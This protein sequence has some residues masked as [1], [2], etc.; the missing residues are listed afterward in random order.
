MANSKTQL[1]LCVSG[2]NQPS[3]VLT[4]DRMCP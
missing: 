2:A 3:A 4:L 1:I